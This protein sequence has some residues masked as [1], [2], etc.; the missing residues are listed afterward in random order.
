MTIFYDCRTSYCSVLTILSFSFMP[1]SLFPSPPLLS[2]PPPSPSPSPSMSSVSEPAT[3]PASLTRC[4]AIAHAV[5]AS[6]CDA[7]CR[8]EAVE[9]VGLQPLAH[10]LAHGNE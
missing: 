10:G 3:L 9:P 5:I 8:N 4:T 6:S 7:A 2:P 1:Y